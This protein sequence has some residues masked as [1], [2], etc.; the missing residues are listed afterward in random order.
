M[1]FIYLKFQNEIIH[2]AYLPLPSPK[3]LQ[4]PTKEKLKTTEKLS[5]N[6]GN[7][8]VRL[9]TKLPF[10]ND[11]LLANGFVAKAS[12]IF[13]FIQRK[14]VFNMLFSRMK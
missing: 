3:L 1:A 9:G 10:H 13:G 5:G 7:I 8:I 11:I 2:Q 14:A 12:Q 4:K 6:D